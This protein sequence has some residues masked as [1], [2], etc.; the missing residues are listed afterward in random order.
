MTSL[1]LHSPIWVIATKRQHKPALKGFSV[2]ARTS[3]GVTEIYLLGGFGKVSRDF[4]FKTREIVKG[5]EIATSDPRE[6][7][8]R[9]RASNPKLHSSW[10]FVFLVSTLDRQ[11]YIT[12]LWYVF[13]RLLIHRM[14]KKIYADVS[15]FCCSIHKSE[16]KITYTSPVARTSIIIYQSH[17]KL[18]NT[19]HDF[20]VTPV[21]ITWC[22]RNISL[23]AWRRLWGRTLGQSDDGWERETVEHVDWHGGQYI[24]QRI[25]PRHS[26]RLTKLSPIRCEG[27][28]AKN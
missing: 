16:I 24:P 25:R 23:T 4:S 7:K 3:S 27:Y 15:S 12:N 10:I 17:T 2:C 14:K 21:S 28:C 1:A 9:P 22:E 26:P 8:E 5:K 20:L 19:H 13:Q 11:K 6:R 18:L